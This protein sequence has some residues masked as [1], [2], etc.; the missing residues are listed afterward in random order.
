MFA[1]C[2]DSE[3]G[4]TDE[5]LSA[6]E[7]ETTDSAVEA[8]SFFEPQAD[9]DQNHATSSAIDVEGERKNYVT[10]N[11][12]DKP[13]VADNNLSPGVEIDG[14]EEL[15]S[16]GDAEIP[17]VLLEGSSGIELTDLGQ[18][19]RQAEKEGYQSILLK[20]E[21]ER[22]EE[23]K[24]KSYKNLP[25]MYQDQ[26]IQLLKTMYGM[27]A[28]RPNEQK[29]YGALANAGSVLFEMGEVGK[30]FYKRGGVHSNEP[31]SSSSTPVVEEPPM[32]DE[33]QTTEEENKVE[34][35]LD[36]KIDA[37]EELEKGGDDEKEEITANDIKDEDNINNT[38]NPNVDNIENENVE[39]SSVNAV[40]EEF[41]ASCEE[42]IS[43]ND[44]NESANQSANNR[45]DEILKESDAREGQES[46]EGDVKRPTSF[47]K[48]VGKLD[49]EWAITFEQFLASMLMEPELVNYFEE[50]PDILPLMEAYRSKK[51]LQ[52]QLSESFSGST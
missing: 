2:I 24:R 48:P 16:M 15:S 47:P 37:T 13:S 6:S 36:E 20:W 52:R 30:R 14:S 34:V 27:F 7:G 11:V 45:D 18:K 4:A 1:K 19:R 50:A 29:L 12:Q 5:E 43:N 17:T 8:T 49:T 9:A 42:S 35:K 23:E 41:P 28:E 22:E 38:L 39:P 51:A 44:D 10:N 40:L 46:P 3:N 33:K 26:F 31:S 32:G 25:M 21:R